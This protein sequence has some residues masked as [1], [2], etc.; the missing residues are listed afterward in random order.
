M[1]A[2]LPGFLNAAGQEHLYSGRSLTDQAPCIL[3]EAFDGEIELAGFEAGMLT[4]SSQ[5]DATGWVRPAD[6]RCDGSVLRSCRLP[7]RRS[8]PV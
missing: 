1:I 5:H 7:A 3:N 2:I 8:L 6:A 4:Q